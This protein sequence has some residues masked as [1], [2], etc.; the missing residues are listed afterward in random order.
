MVYLKPHLEAVYGRNTISSTI[1]YV[2]KLISHSLVRIYEQ[3]QR[4]PD[5]IEVETTLPTEHILKPEFIRYQ[6]RVQ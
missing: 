6:Y 3:K 4:S 2:F 1:D 5:T